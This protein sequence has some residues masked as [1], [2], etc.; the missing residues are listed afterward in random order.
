MG[1]GV[2]LLGLLVVNALAFWLVIE[3]FFW[4][5][6]TLHVMCVGWLLWGTLNPRS[7]L[8]GAIQTQTKTEEIWLTFDDGPDECDTAA[9]LKLLKKHD[10]SATFFVIGKKAQEN[11]DLIR[12]IHEDGHQIGNH[13]WNH[14]QKSFWCAGPWRTY[15]EIARCQECI[16]GIIGEAPKVF[17]APVGHHNIFV[18]PVLRRFGLHL[19]G[20][21]SRGFDGVSQDTAVVTARIRASMW[22]GGIVLIHEGSDIALEVVAAVIAHAKENGWAFRLSADLSGK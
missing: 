16:E 5:G 6:V 18:H 1:N 22:P 4:L 21:S 14:S 12:Q 15:R 8:F 11:P 3:G 10:V 20:W 19:V 7:A 13:T 9:I 2:R 17:R